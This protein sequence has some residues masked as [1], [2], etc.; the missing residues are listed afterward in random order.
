MKKKVRIKGRFVD[1][2]KWIFSSIKEILFEIFNLKSKDTIFSIL[3]M[4]LTLVFFSNIDIYNEFNNYKSMLQTLSLTAIQSFISLIGIIIAGL[5]IIISVSTKEFRDLSKK[6]EKNKGLK[7]VLNSFKLL[8]II[9][10]IAVVIL[11]MFHILLFN[12]YSVSNFVFYL[13]TSLASYLFYFVIFYTISLIII[14]IDLYDVFSVYDEILDQ[15]KK[16]KEEDIIDT[17][18]RVTINETMDDKEIIKLIIKDEDLEDEV[19]IKILEIVYSGNPK[20]KS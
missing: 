8:S 18:Y 1:I 6:I 15:E 3:L 10:G 2:V 7:N 16:Y 5:A 19:K 17:I 12:N 9:T 20:K 14:I 4:L 13:F 11:L